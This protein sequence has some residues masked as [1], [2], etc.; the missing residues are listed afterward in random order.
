VTL[1]VT[2]TCGYADTAQVPN[3]VRVQQRVF[4]PLVLRNSP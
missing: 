3:A 1:T 2:D 4:L